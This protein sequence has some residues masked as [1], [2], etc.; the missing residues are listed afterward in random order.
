M[1]KCSCGDYGGPFVSASV[2]FQPIYALKCFFSLFRYKKHTWHTF[3]PWHKYSRH[4]YFGVIWRIHMRLLVHI[5]QMAWPKKPHAPFTSHSTLSCTY[6][7]IV[8]GPIRAMYVKHIQY[9]HLWC[10]FAYGI[11]QI[12]ISGQPYMAWCGDKRA[13]L[14][15][16][17]HIVCPVI[18]SQIPVVCHCAACVCMCVCVW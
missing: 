13:R 4:R 3:A 18:T 11:W 7:S 12:C 10:H 2:I 5:T 1:L 8:H 16:A 6:T 14:Y 15:C 9:T 17:F